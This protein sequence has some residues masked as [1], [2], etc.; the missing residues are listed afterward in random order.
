MLKANVEFVNYFTFILENFT[1]A[2]KYSP[3][4]SE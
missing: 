4:C 2:Q 1:Q 3:Y